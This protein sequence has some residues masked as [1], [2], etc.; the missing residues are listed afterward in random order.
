MT[1]KIVI[2][3][4]GYGGLALAN[5]LA[6]AGHTVAVY[7]K[8]Q[9]AGGRIQAVEQDGF[10]FDLGPSWY[11]MPEI[12]EQYYQLFD[13]SAREELDLVRFSP[14]YKV[15][16]EGHQPL[17]IQ[18]DVNAD[19]ALFEAIEP[20]AGKKL[21]RYVARSSQVYEVAVRHALYNNF[22]RV[23]DVL[24]WP[25]LRHLPTMLPLVWRT[26]DAHVSRW[27]DDIR[28]KQLLEYHMVFLG[29]SPFQAPA[30]YSLM[31]HLDFRSGVYYPRRG[32]LELAR[33]MEQL[34]RSLGVEYHYDAS[35]QRIVLDGDQATGIEL[36]N[37]EIIEADMVVS[38]ADVHHTE[39][40]LLP[41]AA[42]SYPEKYWRKRQPGPGALLVSLGVKGELPQ[43]QHHNL[44]F[45]KRWRENFAAIYETHTVPEHASL[46]VCNPTK[47]DP[48][49][50][51]PGH[52]NLFV[53]L[54]LPAGVTL[55]SAQEAACVDKIVQILAEMADA[56]DLPE[57]IVTQL[58]YG[59]EQFGDQFNAWQYNAFGGESHLLR[60]SV[61]FR[62]RNRSKK[63]SNL[64]Y[65]GAGTL[66]GIGLPMC[67]IS[68]QLTFKRMMGNRRPGP[69]TKEDL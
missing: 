43:L 19:A 40:R 41:P 6:K 26:L 9:A 7:E 11:L 56:P 65:V 63:V 61:I 35:V 28:L 50:A 34:G 15:W 33:S 67:L 12:F 49:L 52:E 55:T 39:T 57:R 54:P 4:A 18:G 21:Q 1:K 13:R 29:S 47:A 23:S 44:Y 16:S 25:L 2:I 58:V 60:Q 27:F 66:P 30:V 53:L 37:G 64:Y 22:T 3:G 20:G 8:N 68:A 31:S 48:S 24:Q 51:P 45:V 10:V 32:M 42:R 17:V 14:G 59:P 36:A 62:T 38:A 46:Y 69:L 5:L